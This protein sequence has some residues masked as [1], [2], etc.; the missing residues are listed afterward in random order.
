METTQPQRW[1][2]CRPGTEW[3]HPGLPTAWV[4]VL[5]RH[6]QP[7]GLS[8]DGYAMPGYCWIDQ[9]GKVQHVLVGQVEFR[10]EPPV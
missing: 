7:G 8:Y 1:A 4:R 6:P 2:R 9:I 5:E 10:D 3:R